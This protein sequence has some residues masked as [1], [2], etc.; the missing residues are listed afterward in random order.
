MR[1]PGAG[2]APEEPFDPEA[3]LKDRQLLTVDELAEWLKVKPR[4][5]YQWVHEQYIPVMKLGALVRFD[6]AS[7]SRWL[8]EREQ[9]GRSRRRVEILVS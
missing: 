5:V 1:W 2:G 7:V 9:P 4:T 3:T 6:P 8:R